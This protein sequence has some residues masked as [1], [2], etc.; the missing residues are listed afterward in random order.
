MHSKS[1]QN[2]NENPESSSDDNR[3]CLIESVDFQWTTPSCMDDR[4][5]G[6]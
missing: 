2:K 3:R 5:I 4:L 1:L 6:C